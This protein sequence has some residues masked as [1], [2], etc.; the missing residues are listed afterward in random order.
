MFSGCGGGYLIVASPEKIP[1]S[2]NVRVRIET[3]VKSGR[4]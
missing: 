2:F 4:A 1:G 3:G